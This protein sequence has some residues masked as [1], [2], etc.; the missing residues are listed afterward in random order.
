MSTVNADEGVEL[1][2][3]TAVPTIGAGSPAE[4]AA[5]VPLCRI[6]MLM[7]KRALNP[8]ASLFNLNRVIPFFPLSEHA[9]FGHINAPL[10]EIVAAH[11]A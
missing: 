8:A 1:L 7:V 4:A 10:E 11:A 6:M 3:F 2:L 5:R 9:C